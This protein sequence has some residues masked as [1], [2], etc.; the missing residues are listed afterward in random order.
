MNE[1]SIVVDYTSY[2]SNEKPINYWYVF[3]VV[4]LGTALMLM[5]KKKN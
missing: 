4:A 3:G 5:F 1:K 2:Q